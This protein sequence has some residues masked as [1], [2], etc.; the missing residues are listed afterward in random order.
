MNSTDG[1]DPR[2]RHD[3]AVEDE[4]NQELES[5]KQ[6]VREME[7]EAE[8]LREMQAQVEKEMNESGQVGGHPTPVGGMEENKEIVD[9]RSVYVGNVDYGSTAEEIQAHFASCG[10]INRITILCDKFT[11]Q[12]KGFAYIEFADPMLVPQACLLN[13]SLFRGR[14]IKVT[15]KRTNVPG[16]SRGRGRGRGRGGRGFN[17]YFRPRGVRGR[18]VYRGF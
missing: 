9:S 1:Q 5:M 14:Q 4:D 16:L 12:P 10:T 15:P 2:N 6:R 11:G 13:D 3:N 7:F 17:P 18:G 8:K